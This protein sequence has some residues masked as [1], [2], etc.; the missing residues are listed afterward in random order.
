MEG[1]QASEQLK[2]ERNLRE[3]ETEKESKKSRGESKRLGSNTPPFP[4][5]VLTGRKRPLREEGG[6]K[7]ERGR[8]GRNRRVKLG[9]RRNK[10]R[11]ST[12]L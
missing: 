4:R 11:Q 10:E 6:R 7:G 12:R 5:D 2:G 3:G 8:E 9:G 1:E